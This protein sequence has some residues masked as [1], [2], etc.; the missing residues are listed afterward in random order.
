MSL[1]Y[2]KVRDY[3]RPYSHEAIVDQLFVQVRTAERDWNKHA[4]KNATVERY[5][6]PPKTPVYVTLDQAPTAAN[7]LEQ[8]AYDQRR[9]V[10]PWRQT[11]YDRYGYPQTVR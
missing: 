10:S 6:L 5:D 8:R 1:A 7:P 9:A 11:Y 2:G 3:L 4:G